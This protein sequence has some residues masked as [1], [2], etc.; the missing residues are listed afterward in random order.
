M[1]ARA[2]GTTDGWAL[3]SFLETPHGALEGATPRAAI[4]QG[5]AERV[6][7]IARHA[8]F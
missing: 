4:E 8:A 2:L 5:R 1:L 6:L 7:E 3:L